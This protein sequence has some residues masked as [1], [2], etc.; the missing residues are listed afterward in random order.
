MSQHSKEIVSL[1]PG[2]W[3]ASIDLKELW[4]ELKGW[5]GWFKVQRRR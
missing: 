1:K 5:R 4:R 3:G 2:M